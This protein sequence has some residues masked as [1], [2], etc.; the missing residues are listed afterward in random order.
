MI[1]TDSRRWREHRGLQNVAERMECARF[2]AAFP[3]NLKKA[4]L[5]MQGL[6]QRTVET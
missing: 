4:W 3:P 2:T 5:V 1:G 6:S